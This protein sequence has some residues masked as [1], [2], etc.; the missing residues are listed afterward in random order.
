MMEQISAHVRVQSREL[1]AAGHIV[2]LN[3]VGP[4]ARAW[5][6]MAYRHLENR[7]RNEN[8]GKQKKRLA[9]VARLKEVTARPA[10]K[11]P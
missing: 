7:Y 1:T 9:G 2:C 6:V 5:P 8:P 3:R 4:G 11:S 10:A